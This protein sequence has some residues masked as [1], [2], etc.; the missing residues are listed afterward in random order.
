[1]KASI[2]L[3]ENLLSRPDSA[4]GICLREAIEA[5][6]AAFPVPRNHKG[7]LPYAVRDLSRLLTQERGA[8]HQS[9]W[10]APRFVAAY[11]H[12]FLPWNLYRLS[13]LLPSLRLSLPAQGHVVDLGSGP[14]TL[15]LA[16]WCF[17]PELRTVPLRFTCFDVAMRPME[18]GRGVLRELAGSGSPWKITLVRK[19]LDAALAGLTV[20]A[21]LMTA[22]NVLNELPPPRYGTLE[23]RLAE[24]MALMHRKLAPEGRLLL[25]EPGN[26]LGGKVIAVARRGALGCGFAPLAPCPHAGPCPMMDQRLYYPPSPPYSGWCHFVYPAVDAP[27]FLISLGKRANLEKES[28]ALSCLLLRKGGEESRVAP[29]QD[30]SPRSSGGMDDLDDLEALYREIMD[31]GDEGAVALGHA[32]RQ[33]RRDVIPPEPGEPLPDL[34]GAKRMYVRVISDY[35]R[36]PHEV[37][38]ARYGC[39]PK[40]LVLVRDAV[41][42]PSGGSVAVS[43]PGGGAAQTSPDASGVAGQT[44]PSASRGAGQMEHGGSGGGAAARDAAQAHDFSIP[45]LDSPEERDAKSGAL[46]VDREGYRPGSHGPSSQPSLSSTPRQPRQSTRP[47]REGVGS[48]GGGRQSAREE[49]SP[50]GQAERGAKRPP[51]QGGETPR[52]R[53][54]PRASEGQGDKAPLRERNRR[55]SNRREEGMPQRERAPASRQ[56]QPQEQ[57]ASRPQGPG[58]SRSGGRGR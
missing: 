54:G 27:E 32:R 58:H 28:L 30:A 2:L 17:C 21:H 51:R 41:R 7:D 22:G 3:T 45:S 33:A 49:R 9:Y 44:S 40:G 36:L 26:R 1:M 14:L 43:L 11:T 29:A 15:P 38:P 13:W 52:E 23:D 10:S 31:G 57:K 25:V 35:I 50:R 4:S 18:I 47:S 46:M 48:S 42:V 24:L 12:F 56:D 19:P 34:H 53:S 16:L 55:P 5:I 20:P 8:L 37:E 6:K 39:S